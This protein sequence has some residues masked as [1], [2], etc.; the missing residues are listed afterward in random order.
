M[1]P[2]PDRGGPKHGDPVDPDPDSDSDSAAMLKSITVKR[3]LE[4]GNNFLGPAKGGFDSVDLRTGN[5]I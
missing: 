2:D 5:R 3:K 1:D 4:K